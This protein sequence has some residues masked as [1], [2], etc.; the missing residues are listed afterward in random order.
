MVMRGSIFVA[1]SK[2]SRYEVDCGHAITRPGA[3]ADGRSRRQETDGRSREQ[4]PIWDLR[5]LIFC[6]WLLPLPPASA[7]CFLPPVP[8]PA[9]C[10][11]FL[12]SAFRLP[13]FRPS[14]PASCPCFLLLLSAFR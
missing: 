8:A 9:V 12:L 13:A 3:G 5:F 4:E 6:S 11:C 14:A 7:S 2:S 10:S 1:I